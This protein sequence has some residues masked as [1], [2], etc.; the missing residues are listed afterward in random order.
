MKKLTAL[1]TITTLTLTSI[2]ARDISEKKHLFGVNG[3]FSFNTMGLDKNS[4][5]K[6]SKNS[7][8]PGG[9]VGISYEFRAPKVFGLEIGANYANKG[10]QQKISDPALEKRSF[11]RL[12]FHTIEVPLI[13]KFYMGKK[14]VFNLN[15]GGYASYSA[16]VQN[17]LK[18][19]FKNNPPSDYDE[20]T[21]HL[22]KDHNDKDI[23][24]ERPFRPYD[25]GVN[26]GFEFISKAGF[27]V[28]A[29]VQQGF[30]DFT[31]PKFILDDDKKVLNTNAII[32]AIIKI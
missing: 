15:V 12:N 4:T 11:N 27:G 1:L 32:Y 2:F 8:K 31:N 21:K 5:Y 30:V 3:G 14:K 20:T 25:A 28:G 26:V 19:D 6:N 16:E 18:L 22:L 9:V 10:V 17:R 23:N 13:M 7:V 24:G 29:R